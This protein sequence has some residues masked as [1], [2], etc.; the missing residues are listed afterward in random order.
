MAVR[1]EAE[2]YLMLGALVLLCVV[3]LSPLVQLYWPRPKNAPSQLHFIADEEIG[4]ER[5]DLLAN[6]NQAKSFADT[7]M[8]GLNKCTDAAVA[9]CLRQRRKHDEPEQLRRRGVRRQEEEDTGA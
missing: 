8:E 7:V 2:K 3:L 4:D 9:R 1:T 6:G 5:D